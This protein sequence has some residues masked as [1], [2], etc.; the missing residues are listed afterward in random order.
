MPAARFVTDVLGRRLD[1]DAPLGDW[2]RDRLGPQASSHAWFSPGRDEPPLPNP[3]FL[4]DGC[5]LGRYK[6]RFAA[7][8]RAHGDLHPGNIMV[9]VGAGDPE[10]G[11]T[12]IDLSRFSEQALLARDPVHLLL[13]LIADAFLTHMSDAAR[14]ELITGLVGPGCAGPLIPQGLAELVET[15][16]EAMLG[17][18]AGRHL[19]TDWHHQWYLALHACALMFTARE[20]FPDRDRWWFFRLAA[21][22]CWAYLDEM[23]V[24]RPP[25][26]TGLRPRTLCEATPVP[27]PGLAPAT[28][29][30]ASPSQAPAAERWA[31]AAAAPATDQTPA[32]LE[33]IWSTF[34]RPS[35]QLAALSASQV[36]G[37]IVDVIKTRALSLRSELRRQWN[38]PAAARSSVDEVVVGLRTV[39]DLATELRTSLERMWAGQL[40]TRSV[41]QTV[42]DLAHAVDDLLTSVRDASRA[43]SSQAS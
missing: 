23:K 20:R 13:C 10:T 26:A 42:K 36:K 32:L 12:L 41:D 40:A 34:E 28:V 9:P 7:R 5:D 31:E 2:V 43:V 22:A 25:Q 24:S 14:D 15:V 29:N 30:D 19:E 4:A 6:V 11:F 8:G 21:R 27:A 38:T 3:V 16:R 1:A 18:G 17:W 37:E 39:A 35:E 33:E